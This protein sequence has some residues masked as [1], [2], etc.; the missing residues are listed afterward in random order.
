VSVVS[1]W[2]GLLLAAET[3]DLV[4]RA[5]GQSRHTM[6]YPLGIGGRSGLI[7]TAGHPSR[8]CAIGCQASS[9]LPSSS[10]A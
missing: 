4:V 9:S 8:R 3:I 5:D 7:Q 2:A 10:A 6:S 1:F